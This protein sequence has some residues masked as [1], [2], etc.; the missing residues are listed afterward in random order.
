M[1]SEQKIKLGS[2]TAKGGFRNEDDVIVRFNNWKVDPLSQKWLLTMG[3]K[4]EEIEFVKA[5]KITGSYKADIQVQVQVTIK[6]KDEIDCQN[7]QVKLVSNPQGFNQIDKRWV[8]NYVDLWNIDPST[9]KLLKHFTGELP[10]YASNPRDPRR[11][12]A[13]EFSEKDRE[14]LLNF[15]KQNK[16]LI[17]TDILKGRGKFSAEWMLVILKIG[18][19]EIRW[20]LKP[21]NYVLNFFD[22]DVAITPR[23]SFNIGKITIQRKGGDGGRTTANMLQFKINPALLVD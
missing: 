9:T 4:L 10:P 6:L 21:M 16:T 22:G 13:D 2:E 17:V 5:T 15:L 12:F 18:D 20:A 11:M 1:N 23:G 7:L 19:E 14:Q 3:Y 8:K